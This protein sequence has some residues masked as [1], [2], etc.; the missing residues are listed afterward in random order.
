MV[1]PDKGCHKGL[2]KRIRK[3]EVYWFEADKGSK[4]LWDTPEKGVIR[5]G[6]LLAPLIGGCHK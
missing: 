1:P 3:S 4:S 5:V 2:S 6:R